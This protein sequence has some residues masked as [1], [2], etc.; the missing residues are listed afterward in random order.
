MHLHIEQLWRYLVADQ[1][2]LLR[3]SSLHP[4]AHKGSQP[5]D[6]GTLY[7]LGVQADR[8]LGLQL[9]D[10]SRTHV[11][12]AQGGILLSLYGRVFRRRVE[13]SLEPVQSSRLHV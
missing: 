1:S 12:R 2:T 3:I 8:A 13:R 10:G 7:A 5:S 9:D 11:D 4:N 6:A